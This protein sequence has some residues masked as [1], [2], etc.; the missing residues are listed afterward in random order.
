[1]FQPYS[2]HQ[3]YLHGGAEP[4]DTFHIWILRL[5]DSLS[6]LTGGGTVEERTP[7]HMVR[8][9]GALESAT[10]VF[11]VSATSLGLLGRPSLLYQIFFLW[12]FLKDRVPEAYHDYSRTQ[13]S[14]CGRSCAYWWGPTEARVRQ[15][16]DTLATMQC[17]GGHL[18]YVI[19]RKLA[20]TVWVINSILGHI[21]RRFRLFF[22]VS[23]YYLCPFETCQS[24][25]RH[26]V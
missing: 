17:N 20:G 18:P 9:N 24:A 13:T 8:N 16:P 1:M 22:P 10:P 19:C 12:G 4:T 21:Y 3:V 6:R 14:H 15:L 5:R 7:L 23:I 26:S 11:A 25:R 2:H